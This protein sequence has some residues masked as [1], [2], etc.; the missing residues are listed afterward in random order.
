MFQLQVQSN[1]LNKLFCLNLEKKMQFEISNRYYFYD[2][3]QTIKYLTRCKNL[4]TCILCHFLQ[5]NHFAFDSMLYDGITQTLVLIQIT[6]NKNHDIHYG[7]IEQMIKNQKLLGDFFK[8]Y[9]DFFAN[10]NKYHLVNK[11]VFQW[12]TDQQYDVLVKRSDE[13]KK[14]LEPGLMEIFPFHS[15]LIH[16][17]EEYISKK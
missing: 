3:L 11:Y 2:C 9:N 5:A 17:I 15:G 4:E 6:I 1:Y 10:L 7:Q 14:K 13:E 8:K 12:I 16:E